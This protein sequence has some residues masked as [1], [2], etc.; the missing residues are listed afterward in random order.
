MTRNVPTSRDLAELE[1]SVQAAARLMKM[2]ASEQ[3]L[4]LLCR[5]FEG[6]AS[7][8]DLARHAGLTQTA[9]S[10]HLAKM[11]SE[12][13]VATRRDAQTIYYRLADDA[14]QRVLGTL[15]DIYQSP[16]RNT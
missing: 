13:L 12:G 9:A 4:L 11:R 7:V 16:K 10:Q 5:L 1:A 15:C 14:A 3:R 2:L 6:E 8:G